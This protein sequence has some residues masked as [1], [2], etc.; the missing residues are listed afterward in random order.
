MQ[1]QM[2]VFVAPFLQLRRQDDPEHLRANIERIR[3]TVTAAE[4]WFQDNETSQMFR[5]ATG[6]SKAI[7]L[8]DVAQLQPFLDTI[9]DRFSDQISAIGL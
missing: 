4:G 2:W 5:G 8:D 7:E 1:P 3:A 6:G 9:L